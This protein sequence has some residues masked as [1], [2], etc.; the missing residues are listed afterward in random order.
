MI[1]KAQFPL[2]KK[3]SLYDC[4]IGIEGLKHISKGD[5]PLLT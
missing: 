2:L 1:T 5:W 3:L 4:Q